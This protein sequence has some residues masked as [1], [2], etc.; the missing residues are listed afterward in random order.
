MFREE[1]LTNHDFI[2]I[3][4]SIWVWILLSVPSSNIKQKLGMIPVLCQSDC[5]IRNSVFC[6]NPTHSHGGLYHFIV[7]NLVYNM[8]NSFEV[9]LKHIDICWTYSTRGLLWIVKIIPCRRHTLGYPQNEYHESCW[10][11]G[12]RNQVI[13]SHWIDFDHATHCGFSA[14]GF[15][16]YEKHWCIQ[17]YIPLGCKAFAIRLI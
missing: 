16:G 3:V 14:R 4:A 8:L 12:G 9:I 7:Y 13:N 11:G 15:E 2:F 5:Q 1:Q 6:N 10:P 17:S